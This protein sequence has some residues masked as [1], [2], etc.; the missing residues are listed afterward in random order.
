MQFAICSLEVPEDPQPLVTQT[1][2]TSA[3]AKAYAAKHFE[4]VEVLVMATTSRIQH[5]IDLKITTEAR[6]QVYGKG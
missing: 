4:G 1:F 2:A 6:G 3:E 5:L